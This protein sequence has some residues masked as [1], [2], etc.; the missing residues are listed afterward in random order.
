MRI[1]FNSGQG[2][3]LGHLTVCENACQI[4][5]SRRRADSQS[6]L[7]GSKGH[8]TLILRYIRYIK[9]K[10]EGQRFVSA[11]QAVTGMRLDL[12]A[13]QRAWAQ[14]ASAC[15]SGSGRA[16][17]SASPEGQSKFAAGRGESLV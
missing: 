16:I 17:S 10:K 5:C 13:V 2:L 8:R 3:L 6:V 12:S 15:A 7:G 4:S 11:F 14:R 1:R 9:S